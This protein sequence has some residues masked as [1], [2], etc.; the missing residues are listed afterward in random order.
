MR[1][2]TLEVRIDPEATALSRKE[3]DRLLPRGMLGVLLI[4]IQHELAVTSPNSCLTFF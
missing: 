2:I 4:R 3:V 1:G